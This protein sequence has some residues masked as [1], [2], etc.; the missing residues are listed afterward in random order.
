MAIP[1]H[2][3]TISLWTIFLTFLKLGCTAFGGPLAHIGFFHQ[4]FVKTKHWLANEDFASLVAVCQFIPGPTSSQVGMAIGLKQGRY[5]GALAAWVGFTAPSALLMI[6][7]AFVLS[8]EQSWRELSLFHGLKLFA[9]AVV[10]HA[11]WGMSQQLCPDFR[12]RIWVLIAL[13]LCLWIEH[14]LSQLSVIGL[15]GLF[16]YCFLRNIPQVQSTKQLSFDINK[17]ASFIAF[18]L[19]ISIFIIGAVVAAG[20][21]VHAVQ[22][23][24]SFYRAGSLVFGG[25]HVVLPLLEAEFVESGQVELQTF[26]SG[27]GAAQAIPGPLF[28]FAAF[29]GSSIDGG[30]Y[31]VFGGLIAIVIIFLPSILLLIFILPLWLKIQQSVH[32]QFVVAGL[33]TGVVGLLSAALINPIIVSSIHEPLDVLFSFIIF[34]IMKTRIPLIAL[35]AGVICSSSLLF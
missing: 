4:T 29:L 14:P 31:G 3:Q 24:D 32:V 33:N 26:L 6:G 34:I 7:L 22:V 9:I 10:M 23:F 27:Y 17:K 30:S 21:N 13:C 19:F 35:L 5:L 12:R 2:E 28:T 15:S 8:P 25:G 1:K 16:G 20:F 11:L 18:A